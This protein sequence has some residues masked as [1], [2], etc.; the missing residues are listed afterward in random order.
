MSKDKTPEVGD[1]WKANRSGIV[2]Y[3]SAIDVRDKR[4]MFSMAQDGRTK[5]ILVDNYF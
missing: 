1:I 5:R 3:L 2:F 4:M